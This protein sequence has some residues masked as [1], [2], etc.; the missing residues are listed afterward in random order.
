MRTGE[1]KAKLNDYAELFEENKKIIYGMYWNIW[2]AK[3]RLEIFGDIPNAIAEH[4]IIYNNTPIENRGTEKRFN[5]KVL[6]KYVIQN[7][8]DGK[9]YF[10]HHNSESADFTSRFTMDKSQKISEMVAKTIEIVEEGK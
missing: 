7:V 1:L 3:Q 10:H 6:D 2:K 5:I 9:L 8:H 4:L